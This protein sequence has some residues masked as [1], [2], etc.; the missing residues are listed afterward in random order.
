MNDTIS[1]L[2]SLSALAKYKAIFES[3]YDCKCITDKQGIIEE[4]NPVA[5]QFFSTPVIGESILDVFPAEGQMRMKEIWKRR[6]SNPRFV[7]LFF[8]EEGR[9]EVHVELSLLH[10]VLPKKYLIIFRDVT[11]RILEQRQHD[12]FLAVASHELKTPLAV[13][14]AFSQLLESK[15]KGSQDK[16]IMRYIQHIEDKTD[17]LAQLVADIVDSIRIGSD[18]LKF[19]DEV[20]D[21]DEMAKTVVE[22]LQPTI[23]GNPIQV[24]GSTGKKICIDKHRFTQ[25]LKN[26]LVNAANSSSPKQTVRLTLAASGSFASI[27]VEDKGRGL[28]KKDQ[29]QVFLPFF[30]NKA[31]ANTHSGTGLGLYLAERIVN[32]YHGKIGVRST[33]RKG[34]SFTVSF[35]IIYS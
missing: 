13:M 15:L 11:H 23:Q 4:T 22:E 20:L 18:R 9:G 7:P 33:Y 19:T 25:I 21:V 35:P 2:E 12:Q 8:H 3:S 32:R 29:S 34:S 14:K 24:T 17:L 28:S 16:T 27:T 31:L 26:L 10:D 30:R 1:S 6:D 5:A